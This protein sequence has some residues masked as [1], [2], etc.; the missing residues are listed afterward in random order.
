[1]ITITAFLMGH[2]IQPLVNAILTSRIILNLMQS[3]INAHLR[4]W[5]CFRI[6]IFIFLMFISKKKINIKIRYIVMMYV[7]M[8]VICVMCMCVNHTT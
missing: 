3:K 6:L 5:V 7:C 4:R 8:C 1:M 2:S